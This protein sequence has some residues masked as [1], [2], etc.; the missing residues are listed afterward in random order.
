M[1]PQINRSLADKAMDR[2]DH[3]LGRPLNPLSESYR[4]RYAAPAGSREAEEMRGSPYWSEGATINRGTL[5]MFHVTPAGEDALSAHLREIGDPHRAYAVTFDGHTSIVAATSRT[6][7]RYRHWL[8]VSDSLSDLTFREYC[9]R[10]S[11]RLYR[12]PAHSGQ[13]GG[14]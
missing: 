4:N 10:T 3:A 5:T 13:E 12:H 1:Q 7:A 9:R 6:R 8:D 11:V 14:E 2:I